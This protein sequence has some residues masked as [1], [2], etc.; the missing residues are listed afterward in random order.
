MKFEFCLRRSFIN[1]SLLNRAGESHGR[2]LAL[3]IG[4]QFV[5]NWE[6]MGASH[7]V[8]ANR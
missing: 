3:D 4:I 8:S 7:R 1:V 6:M 5:Y 2:A